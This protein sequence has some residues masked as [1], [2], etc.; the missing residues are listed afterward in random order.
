VES[1][2][3]EMLESRA[4]IRHDVLGSREVFGVVVVAVFTLVVACNLA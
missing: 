3:G 4:V 1:G 2:I